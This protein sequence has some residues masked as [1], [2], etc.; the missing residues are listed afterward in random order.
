MDA[1]LY[2]PSSAYHAPHR[3]PQP[4]S[5]KTVSIADL[6]ANPAA[7]AIL[8]REIPGLEMRLNIDQIKP[9]LG[10]FAFRDLVQFGFVKA[11]PLDR[12]D[13]QLK[14]LPATVIGGQ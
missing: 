5:T 13:E 4:M 12:A 11:E 1:P 9:H 10:N 3:L 6:M 2:L 14:A 8:V 7:K